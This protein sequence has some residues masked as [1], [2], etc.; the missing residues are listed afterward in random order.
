MESRACV[1]RECM[2]LRV[3]E[4]VLRD[5]ARVRTRAWLENIRIMSLASSLVSCSLVML[6]VSTD[7]LTL[8]TS[9]PIL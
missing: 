1:V 2:C 3:Q 9:I 6:V 7:E 5:E 8:L 4:Y